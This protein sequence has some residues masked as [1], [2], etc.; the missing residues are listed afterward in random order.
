MAALVLASGS[1]ARARMLRDAGVEIEIAVAAIDETE[2][3]RGFRAEGLAS[4]GV[5][6]ALAELKAQRVSAKFPGR[7]V[8]GADQML[9][10]AGIWFEK[11]GDLAAARR[12]LLALRGRM[13]RLI[14][15]AVLVKDGTRLWHHTA[16]AE[17]TMRDFTEGFLDAYLAVAGDTVLASVGAYQ[18]E[19]L[20]AQLVARIEG[21]FFTILG[22]PLL[23]VLD[24]LREQGM[25]KT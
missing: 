12:H 4:V 8:L 23:A 16:A 22:L 20:G 19:G 5:A 2:L 15:S 11:P 3:M 6:E 24:I 1:Q 17:L 10:C 9:D 18:L 7:L 13:H 25:L 21:D 14:S